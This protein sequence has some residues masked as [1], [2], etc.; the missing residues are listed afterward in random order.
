M[1]ERGQ[2][3]AESC[4]LFSPPQ[5]AHLRSMVGGSSSPDTEVSSYRWV[6]PEIDPHSELGS[7]VW[8]PS[9]EHGPWGPS[10]VAQRENP[11][12]SSWGPSVSRAARENWAK[13]MGRSSGPEV[14]IK[15][16]FSSQPGFLLKS[17]LWLP[18]SI[19]GQDFWRLPTTRPPALQSQAGCS[20]QGCQISWRPLPLLPLPDSLPT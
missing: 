10:G 7:G 13:G 18:G 14:W 9:G 1:A 2:A 19:L 20:L 16:T 3:P 15:S 4:C 11:P 12:F 5:N 6:G 17:G 8:T